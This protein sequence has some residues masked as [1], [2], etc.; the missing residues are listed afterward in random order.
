MLVV[1][2]LTAWPLIS[3]C[4]LSLTPLGVARVRVDKAHRLGSNNQMDGA[5]LRLASFSLQA[6]LILIL[7]SGCNG[8]T[9]SQYSRANIEIGM[10]KADFLH[11]FPQAELRG[12]KKVSDGTV[13][14]YALEISEYSPFGPHTQGSYDAVTG[15]ETNH[16]WFSFF[17]GS[18][19]QFGDPSDW[20]D[21][22]VT[23]RIKK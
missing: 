6:I 1:A 7:I 18:L 9:P 2:S 14:V 5:Q 15:V 8:V 21:A 10:S 12:A 3:L 11:Q 16:R 23:L 20:R 17:N 22:D 19:V 13:E 4:C